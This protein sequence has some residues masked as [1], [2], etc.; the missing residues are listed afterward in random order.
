MRAGGHTIP[1]AP[2]GRLTANVLLRDA[3]EANDR[4]VLPAREVAH[5]QLELGSSTPVDPLERSRA[6]RLTEP[7]CE[8]FEEGLSAGAASRVLRHP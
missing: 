5:A 1:L 8:G 4:Q 2:R 6:R 7:A 3:F